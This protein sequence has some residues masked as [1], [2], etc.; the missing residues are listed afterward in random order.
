MTVL[1]GGSAIGD[2]RAREVNKREIPVGSDLPANA[3]PTKVVMPA[4]RALD[5]PTS[6]ATAMFALALALALADSR[7]QVRRHG[8][9]PDVTPT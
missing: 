1:A 9:L 7:E 2:Q 5:D 6:S 8:V 3:N 4:V